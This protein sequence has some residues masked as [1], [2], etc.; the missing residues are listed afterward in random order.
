[1]SALPAPADAESARNA[2]VQKRIGFFGGAFD[3]PHLAHVALARLAVSELA[4]DELHVVPTGHAWHKTRTLTDPLHRLRMTQLAFADVPHVM[5]DDREI[6]RSGPSYTIETLQALQR[7]APTAQLYLIMG[8]DQFAA[9]RQWH[10]WQD[11]LEIAIICIAGRA[12]FD[13]AASRFDAYKG[14]QHRFLVL[15]L[16]PTAISATQ[17]RRL[18]AGAACDL[19]ELQ[20]LHGLVPDPVARYISTHRLYCGH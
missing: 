10:C 12:Q 2:A 17:I 16:P 4:L 9:F 13:W 15:P 3:P 19:Q 7:E 5:V 14:L 8:A 1:M 18:V 11:I 6:L 20:Y